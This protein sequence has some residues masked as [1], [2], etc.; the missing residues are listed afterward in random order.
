MTKLHALIFDVDGTLAETERDA[1]R[2]AFNDTFA[3]YRLNWYWSEE[4]YGELLAITGGK[5]RIKFYLDRYLPDYPR[6]DNIDQFVAE[7]HKNK[8]ARYN[9]ML[10]KNPIP[11]RPG[12]RRLL[13]EARREGIRLAIATTTSL[14]NVTSLLEYSLAPHSTHWF[15]VIAAGDMVQAKKP[16]SDI[17][18]HALNE[19]KLD[20]NQCIAFE[21]SYN[22]LCA[23]KGAQLCTI[24]TVNDY[25]RHENFKSAQLV[26]N[27]LGEPDLPFTVLAGDAS[28]ASYIDIAWLQQL[29]L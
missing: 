19:L 7:L 28:G 21:D 27:H 29:V 5:E 3:E 10:V 13:E 8:T 12:I 16:A 2:G 9:Q 14:E 1:H 17:Y 4:L 15:D 23:A 24:I 6:P 26:L 18:H 20:A 25:T 22:G 11:L